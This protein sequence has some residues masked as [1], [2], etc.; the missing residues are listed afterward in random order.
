MCHSIS[1]LADVNELVKQFRIDRL[2]SYSSNRYEVRPTESVSAV[3]MNKKGERILDEFRWGLMPFWAK[4]AVCGDRDS[5][6]TNVVFERIVRKQRCIIPC[7]GFYIS[8]TEGKETEWIKFK[9]R[10]GTFGIAGLYDVW[11][12]PSGEEEL[13]TCMMLMTEANSL[14]SPYQRRMPAIL[15][16][17]Q[18]EMWLQPEMKDSRLLRSILRPVDDLLMVANVL[19]S[20]EEKL[21]SGSDVSVFV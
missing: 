16:Q 2:L 9:M 12:A 6:F 10:S 15:D 1:I 18:A 13:R 21:E 3:M 7:S 20:P 4:D 8:V 17:D 11:R 5:I 14:V 19:S